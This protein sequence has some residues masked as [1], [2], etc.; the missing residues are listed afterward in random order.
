MLDR[1]HYKACD[2]STQTTRLVME[3]GSDLL[4]VPGEEEVEYDYIEESQFNHTVT[5]YSSVSTDFKDDGE[6]S[7]LICTDNFILIL[8][9][10]CFLH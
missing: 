7:E 4:Y 1:K 5:G 10:Y 6:V 2:N 3:F 8:L 9:K